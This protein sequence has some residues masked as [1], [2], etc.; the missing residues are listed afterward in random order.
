MVVAMEWVSQITAIALVI[1]G[2]IW[3]GKYL[4][5]RLGTSFLGLIGLFVGPLVGFFQLLILTGVVS[6]RNKKSGREENPRQ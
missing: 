6:R 2:S 1:V 3:L 4:D 5:K